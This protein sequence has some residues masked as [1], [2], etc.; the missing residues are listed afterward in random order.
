[1]KHQR[2][3]EKMIKELRDFIDSNNRSKD[4]AIQ[5][6]VSDAYQ[7]ECCLVWVIHKPTWNPIHL[8]NES[9]TI[10]R[11]EGSDDMVQKLDRIESVVNEIRSKMVTRPQLHGCPG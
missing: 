1:M 8:V 6:A 2:T 10:V 11:K 4:F 9:S 7:M 3:I 5:K